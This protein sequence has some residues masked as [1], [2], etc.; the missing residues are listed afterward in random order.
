MRAFIISIIF[1]AS[2]H[3]Y[4]S[5][6]KGDSPLNL[7]FLILI[8]SPFIPFIWKEA[9]NIKIGKNGLELERLKKDVDHTIKKA[10]HGNSIDPKAINDLFKTVELNEWITLVLA[11]ML[12]RKGLISLVSNHNL[13]DTPSL[14][15]LISLAFDG[16]FLSEEEKQDI[17]KLRNI[18]FYAEWWNGDVPTHTEW[19]WALDNCKSIVKNIFEKQPIA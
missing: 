8:L 19:N 17:D 9:S 13:G 16:N 12:L 10:A 2:L 1:I 11:R 6:S 7:L 5:I 15:K 18:T 14:I 3:I 4:F